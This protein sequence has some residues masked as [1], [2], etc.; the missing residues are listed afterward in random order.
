MRGRMVRAQETAVV[1]QPSVSVSLLIGRRRALT[2]GRPPAFADSPRLWKPE[3]PAAKG[4]EVKGAVLS[5]ERRLILE[6]AAACI[7]RLELRG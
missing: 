1:G 4:L 7:D 5:A 2:A 6:R 3:L